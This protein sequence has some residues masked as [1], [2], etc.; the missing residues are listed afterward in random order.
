MENRKT[1]AKNYYQTNK[2]KLQKRS[3]EH[4]SNLS[5]KMRKLK[6]EIMLILK[7]K[8]FQVQ[9]EKEERIYEQLLL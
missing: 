1:R 4:Y 9:I 7:I 2:E 8:I 5:K 3:R 6:K